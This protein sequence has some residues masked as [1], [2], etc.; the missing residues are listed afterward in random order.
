MSKRWQMITGLRC[1]LDVQWSST[2]ILTSQIGFYVQWTLGP[3][4]FITGAL[5][6]LEL[7]SN[8]HPSDLYWSSTVTSLNVTKVLSLLELHWTPN[9]SRTYPLDSVEFHWNITRPPLD[10]YWSSNGS[11]VDSSGN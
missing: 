8:G 2:R 4:T 1:P 7:S 9:L 5:L 3:V 6:Q 10:I 11:P